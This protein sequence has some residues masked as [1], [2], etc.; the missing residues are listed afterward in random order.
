MLF[1]FVLSLKL[2]TY[3]LCIYIYTNNPINFSSINTLQPPPSPPP[4]QGSHTHTGKGRKGREMEKLNSELYLRNCRIIQ[5]NERLRKRAQQLDKEN[6]ALLTELK[7]KLSEP[8]CTQKPQLDLQLSSS[9]SQNEKNKS[10][11]TKG[12]D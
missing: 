1:F 4:I 7:Q 2:L 12:Q 9:G 8:N 3:T 11:K 10:T 5:E 6:Q